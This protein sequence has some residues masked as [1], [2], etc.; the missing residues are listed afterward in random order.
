MVRG[1]ILAFAALLPFGGPAQAYDL[2]RHQWQD[3]L[4]ILVAPRADDPQLAAQERRIKERRDAMHDRDLRVLRLFPDGG[5]A[6]DRTL[7]PEDTARLRG[8]LDVQP[9][10]RQLILIGKDG[11]IKRRAPLDTD[12]REVFVQ[13]DAMPMRRGEMRSKEAAGIGVTRP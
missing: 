10:D 4:L 11:G 8:E 2:Q 6:A 12:L 7:S 3:R 1:V 13:I 5:V 9:G